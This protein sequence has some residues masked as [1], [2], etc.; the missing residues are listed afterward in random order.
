MKTQSELHRD[1]IAYWNGVGGKHWV[2]EQAR[3]D[4]MLA[5]IAE[6]LLAR[7]KAQPGETVLD[8]GS[9]CGDTSIELARH[10]LPGGRVVGL[11]VSAPMVALAKKLSGARDNLEFIVADAATHPFAAP[12]ADLLIS[13]FG[14]MFF[15]DP[16]A[17][18]ANLRKALKPN[19]RIV[20]ACWRK[21]DE[22]PWMQV[23][24]RA[25]YAHV[26]HLPQVGPEEP[27]PFSFADPDRVTRILTE[28]GFTTPR[29]TPVDLMLDIAAGGGLDQAMQQATTIGAT[30]RALQDQPQAAFDAALGAI[31]LALTPYVKGG[32]VALPAAI[33][34][35]ES[36]IG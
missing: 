18:F 10:V 3:T 5:P 23:P 14:V 25:A 11:D 1:Q 34:L 6:A 12:F 24:L 20:F 28:S 7:A 36:E 13:R 32:S 33:W 15:G 22:N 30:S 2:E 8:V 17:A 31:R 29:L 26:P 16:T 4:I 19:G 35:V 9:G 27:G 21:F